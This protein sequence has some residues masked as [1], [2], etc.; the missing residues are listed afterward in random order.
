MNTPALSLVLISSS[1]SF[2]RY[3]CRYLR[4]LQGEAK[5]G[6]TYGSQRQVFREL[7]AIFE[8]SPVTVLQFEQLLSELDSAIKT[9]YSNTQMSDTDRRNTEKDMLISATIPSVL[10]PAIEL[11]LRNTIENLKEEVNEA[12]LYFTDVS[13][14]GLSDDSRSDFWRSN[15]ILDAVR[16][17][18]LPKDAQVRKCTR[19]CAIIEDKY[20]QKGMSIF[21]FL[22]RFCFC[23]NWWMIEEK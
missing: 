21:V 5:S 19:C 17:V 16:K 12:E 18:E 15:H 13:W 9:A 2:L 4:G 14:L 1:R 7:E 8:D 11:F 10:F 20:Q 3:N 6:Q 23:G 22:Q